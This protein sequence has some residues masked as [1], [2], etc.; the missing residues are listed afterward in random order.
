[1]S[2]RPGL[3]KGLYP[4]NFERT[5]KSITGVQIEIIYIDSFKNVIK[6]SKWYPFAMVTGKK[7]L[8]ADQNISR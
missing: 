8:R 4:H 3:L 5:H 1:M 6:N 2:L 7:C